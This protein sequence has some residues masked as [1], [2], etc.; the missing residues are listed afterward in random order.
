MPSDLNRHDWAREVVLEWAH[1]KVAQIS[2]PAD[3]DLMGRCRACQM[4]RRR[5]EVA[6]VERDET[7][8]YV[9]RVCGDTIDQS[10]TY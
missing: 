3:D 9:C 7:Y 6:E 10:P 2:V 5:S 1:A 4:W 8:V